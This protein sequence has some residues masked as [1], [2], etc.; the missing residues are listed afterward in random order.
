MIKKTIQFSIGLALLGGFVYTL[1]YLYK[2]SEEKPMM[3]ITEEP[4]ISNVI[5]KTVA[6]GSVVPKK[7]VIIKPNISGIITEIYV[8][9]GDFIKAGDIIAKVKI[10]PDLEKLNA[11]ENRVDRAKLALENA[12]IDYKRS[13]KLLDDKVIAPA[14]FQPVELAKKSAI[15]ELETA[16]DNLDI[17]REGA[18][19]K[20][21][22]GTN[23]LIKATA[24]GMILDVTVKEG[25]SVIETNAFNEGTPIASIADMTDMIFEGK[26]DESEVGK[27]KLGMPLILSIGAIEN[28]KFS[29]NLTYISPKGKEENGAVQFEIK[30]S[31]VLND[32]D[33]VRAGY[34][35]NADIVLERVDS[36]LC[37]NESLLQFEDGE[38]Y[39][40]LEIASQEFEK[41]TIKTGLSD[42]IITQVLEGVELGHKI[43]AGMMPADE[44]AKR[45]ERNKGSK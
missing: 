43:K 21:S 31:L 6:T 42:G 7:E 38:T 5:K 25:N 14:D 44:F 1:W 29:A 35:A 2:K 45:E 41:R 32:S 12:E 17:I 18:S 36:V 24:N 22:V 9:A 40:E 20:S 19:K 30:A 27:L 23:T 13:K 26:V 33:F 39:I 28:K 16:Q 10:I 37:L 3:A 8:E 11:A 4:F 34:S 15:E